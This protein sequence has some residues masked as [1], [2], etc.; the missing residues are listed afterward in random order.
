LKERAKAGARG[1]IEA[2][3][4]D[5]PDVSYLRSLHEASFS[6]FYGIGLPQRTMILVDR[7]KGWLLEEDEKIST[8][9]LRRLKNA[10]DLSLTMLWHKFGIAVSLR[11]VVTRRDCARELFSLIIHGRTD[12]WCRF[13][14]SATNTIPEVGAQVEIFGWEKWSTRIIEVL[15][16][17]ELERDRET[18]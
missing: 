2:V 6:V 4:E 16:L 15:E 3:V 5:L 9:R 7:Q 11:G 14:D 12:Q 1:T 18:K 17:T 10:E 13:K 8:W